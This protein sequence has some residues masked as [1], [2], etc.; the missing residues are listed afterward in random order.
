MKRLAVIAALPLLFG[1]DAGHAQ[2]VEAAIEK[3][4]IA[5]ESASTRRACDLAAADYPVVAVLVLAVAEC[6]DVR[7]S[8]AERW[9]GVLHSALSEGSPGPVEEAEARDT[10]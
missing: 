1:A 4:A 6:C 5:W 2:D 10:L 3:A 9:Q 8:L 7:A